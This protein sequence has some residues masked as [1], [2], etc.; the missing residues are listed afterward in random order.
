M[1]HLNHWWTGCPVYTYKT[2]P[3]FWDRAKTYLIGV[4]LATIFILVI[5]IGTARAQIVAPANLWKGLIAESTKGDIEEYRCIASVVRNRLNKGMWH[6]LVALK[7]KD[8]DR[9]VA[10]EVAYNP[11]LATLAKKAVQ[12][13]WDYANGAT[14]YEHTGVYPVP[15]WAK[16]MKI[17]KI[18]YKGMGKEITFWKEEV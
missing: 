13:E 16:K 5:F 2:E 6:G 1:T 9:F 10:R 4:L 8:L 14:H 12:E 15:S 18:L 11:I 7:R 17:V 3:S